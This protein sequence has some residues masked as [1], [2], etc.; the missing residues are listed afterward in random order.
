MLPFFLFRVLTPSLTHLEL[1][2]QKDEELSS[3]LTKR[4][5]FKVCTAFHQRGRSFPNAFINNYEIKKINNFNFVL[6]ILSFKHS[7]YMKNKFSR[8]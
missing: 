4:R 6:V 7:D 5:V 1:S 8:M 2:A 3:V